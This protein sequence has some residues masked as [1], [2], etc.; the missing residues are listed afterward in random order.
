MRQVLLKRGVPAEAIVLLPG[1][2]NSTADEA[3][4]LKRYLEEHAGRRV[5]VVTNDYHTRRARWIF[6]NEI[7]DRAADLA[8]FGAPT[9][10]FDAH[11]WWRSETGFR[12]YSDEYVKLLAY[13]VGK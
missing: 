10:D 13:L 11:D 6:R 2:V 5:A 7:G 8:F 9:D 3:R 1:E 12:C 4:A